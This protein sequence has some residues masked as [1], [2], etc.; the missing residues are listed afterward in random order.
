MEGVEE[1]G[2]DD[3]GEEVESVEQGSP[4]VTLAV[5]LEEAE[6]TGGEVSMSMSMSMSSLHYTKTC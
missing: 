4:T 6:E 5:T 2:G 3:I 1:V